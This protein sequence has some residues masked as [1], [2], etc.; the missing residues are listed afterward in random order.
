MTFNP[1]CCTVLSNATRCLWIEVCMEVSV[2]LKFNICSR[3]AYKEK[4]ISIL[5]N[6]LSVELD[7]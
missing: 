6:L 1:C 7:T 4:N 3:N 5:Y 2:C